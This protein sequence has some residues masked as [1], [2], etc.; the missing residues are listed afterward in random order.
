MSQP[1]VSV[2]MV[3]CNV[4]RFLAESIESILGQTF[5]D[6]EFIIL[7][8][9]STDT[10]K[11]IVS[12]YAAKDSRIK[13]REIPHCGLAEARNAVS[14]LAQGRYIAVMDA[15]DVSMP[16]RLKWE[17][18]FMEE[19]QEIGIV[20]GAIQWIDGAGR[21]LRVDSRPTHDD[22]IHKALL[23]HYPFCHSSLLM[24]R[25]AFAR[26]GGYR[27]AFAPAEDYDL[28][29]RMSEYC[30]CANLEQVVL[31]YRIHGTQLSLQ[32]G[33]YQSLAKLAARASAV[34]RRNGNGDPLNSVGEITSAL[35]VGLG[36]TEATQQHAVVLDRYQWIRNMCMAGEYSLALDAAVEMLHSD[37][38]YVERWL[39]AD[40]QLRAAR[41][42][43]KQRRF[44]RSLLTGAQA[45]ARRPVMLGRPLK[46]LFQRRS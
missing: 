39:I 19:H 28:A 25:E 15:D 10:S 8:F 33:K 26:S 44:G 13:L 27:P 30:K 36:V 1:L 35:L 18:S 23:D 34:S 2:V 41:L 37:L 22:E 20:G 32:K 21:P 31:Q 45:F 14:F 12:G 5:G 7:D 3:V 24:R 4:E 9:G 40:L 6:F 43:W 16:D 38:K 11:S 17:S 42:Y 29:I 46:R